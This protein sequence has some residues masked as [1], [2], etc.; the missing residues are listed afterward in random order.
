MSLIDEIPGYREAVR[1]ESFNRDRAF[2]PVAENVCGFALRPMLFGDYL[3]L[4]LICSPFLV[5]G[6]PAPS[7]IRALLW[8]MSPE[9]AAS[10]LKK[11]RN[12]M[13]RCLA[14]LPPPEPWIKTKRSLKRW[15]EKTVKALELQGKIILGLKSYV[16]AACQDWPGTNSGAV[17]AV[18]Y[19]SD[20]ASIIAMIAREYGWSESSILALPMSRLLQYVKEIKSQAGAKV[21]FNPSDIYRQRYA[22]SLNKG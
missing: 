20:G 22:E 16:D 10:D 8:R 7:D 1:A 21:L 3:A 6:E 15:A 9:Y 4:R 12:L 19:Y 13:N 14:F 17:D 11:R 5:G 2:I 18:H